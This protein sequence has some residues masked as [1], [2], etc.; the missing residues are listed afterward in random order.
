MSVVS[1][2]LWV[3]QVLD[4]KAQ[5]GSTAASGNRIPGITASGGSVGVVIRSPDL[6]QQEESEIF[7]LAARSKST[8]YR[9]TKGMS[10]NKW[11]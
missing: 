5:D 2:R 4:R 3:R 1:G 6:L 10:E 9:M 11:F 7:R 8:D